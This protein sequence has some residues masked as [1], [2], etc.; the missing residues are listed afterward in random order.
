MWI[1]ILLVRNLWISYPW[2]T[3]LTHYNHYIY[4][5]Y[6]H[7]IIYWSILLTHY[8]NPFHEPSIHTHDIN[9]S[10]GWSQTT[11]HNFQ[12]SSLRIC[13]WRVSSPPSSWSCRLAFE[14]ALTPWPRG[15]RLGLW[16]N[17]VILNHTHTLRKTSKDKI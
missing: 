8:V 16:R 5:F 1:P 17:I 3:H 13:W 6:T 14:S 11:R 7:H 4:P 12:F 15:E 10:Y 9:S 2:Y